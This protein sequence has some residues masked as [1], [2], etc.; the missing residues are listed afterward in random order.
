[1][2]LQFNYTDFKVF[3][4]K[5]IA[6]GFKKYN[7][8]L[9]NEDY[10]FAKTIHRV[11]DEDGDSRGVLQLFLS[12]YDFSKYLEW[13]EFADTFIHLQTEI[14]VS[15]NIDERIDLS[16]DAD[17]FNDLKEIEAFS[18]KFYEFIE[19]NIKL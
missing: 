8:K 1:M 18:F 16:I 2:K 9:H 13:P 7:G 5:L 3:Q 10:Y 4:E 11:K 6:D 15:R 12:V 14:H 17:R 19:A